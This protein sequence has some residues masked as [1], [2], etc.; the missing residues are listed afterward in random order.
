MDILIFGTISASILLLS[1]IGFSMTLKTEGFINIAHGQALLMGAYLALWLDGLG[2]PLWAAAILASIGCGFTG[3]ILNRVLFKPVKSKGILV[4]LFT[5]VGAAYVIYGIVGA[6][7]GKRMLAFDL[8]P[9]RAWQ[10][11]GQPF[12]TPYEFAIV[13]LAIVSALGVHVFLTYTWAGKSIRAVA[14]NEDLARVRGFDPR[15][16]SDIVWFVATAL[17]GLAGVFLGIVGSLH[18]QMGWQMIIMILAVTV[19]GGLGSIYGVMLASVV[20]A[21]GIEI[22]LM[23]VSSSYRTGLAFALIIAVLLVRPGGLQSLWGGGKTRTH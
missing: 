11:A 12:M 21:F 18:T 14:D 19:L 4:L 16:T 8:P 10:I 7:A 15:R 5:S 3:V 13:L 1:S 22:G 9:M 23:F 2:L 20:L 6:L 17:A